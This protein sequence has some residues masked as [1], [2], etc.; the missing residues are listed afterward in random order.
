MGDVDDCKECSRPFLYDPSTWPK[1]RKLPLQEINEWT[2]AHRDLPP[3]AF[4]AV[5]DPS[6]VGH[7]FHAELQHIANPLQQRV[8]VRRSFRTKQLAKQ[9]AALCALHQ[10][11]LIAEIESEN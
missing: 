1:D 10:M 11:H 4:E 5:S 6:N 2:M 7:R 9:N 3:I 8:V